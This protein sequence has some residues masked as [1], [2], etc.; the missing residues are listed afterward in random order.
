[1]YT[2]DFETIKQVMQE[3]QKTGI[4]SADVPS[5]TASVNGPCHVEIKL[6]SGAI[7]SWLIVG[8]SGRRVPERKVAQELAQLGRLN[9]TFTPLQESVA[10][11]VAPVPPPPAR[12]FPQRTVQV[13]QWQ[14]NNWP[15]IHRLVF[16]LADG[17]KS[18]LKIAEMLSA[19]PEMVDGALRDLQSIG[20]IIMVSQNGTYR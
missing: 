6:I 17:T 13:E 15:R 8:N 10:P 2:L 11:P 20:V 9:W 18:A 16:A 14:M 19:S 4:L 1:M 3:H 7:V 5:G 12:L